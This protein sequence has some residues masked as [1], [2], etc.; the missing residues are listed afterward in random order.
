VSIFTARIDE[1]GRFTVYVDGAL[2]A[3]NVERSDAL[4]FQPEYPQFVTVRLPNF[5]VVKVEILSTPG[6]EL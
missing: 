2:V 1:G 5:G 4:L 6:S 3:R